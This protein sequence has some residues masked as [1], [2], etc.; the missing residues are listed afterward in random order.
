MEKTDVLVVGAGPAGSVV[1]KTIA[2]A[3]FSVQI[4]EEHPVVGLPLACGEGMS[5][6]M[7]NRFPWA[8]KEGYPLYIQYINFPGGYRTYS[9]IEAISLNRTVFDQSLCEMA[10][11]EG[12]QLNTNTSVKKLTRTR[13]GIE[14]TTN[15]GTTSAKVVIAADGPSSRMMRQMNLSPPDELIQ[16]IEY[17]IRDLEAE[18]LQFHFDYTIAPHGYGWIFDKGE[19]TANVGIC[20]QG[21][22]NPRARLDQFMRLHNINGGIEQ[23]IAGIIPSSGPVKQCYTD[24]FMVVGDAGGFTNPMFFGGI[25]IAMLTGMIAGET[26]V[27]ALEEDNY[28]ADKLIS[29]SQKVNELP[30][31][32]PN[33]IRAHNLF[34][35][36]CNNKDL[37][38]IGILTDNQDITHLTWGKKIIVFGRTLRRPRIWGG[39]SKISKIM[40]GFRLSRDWGF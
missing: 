30:I 7:L 5:L 11:N 35:H 15:H 2:E 36:Q 34:Y 4:H 14:A 28:S 25:G 23:V 27:E 9:S 33:L 24:H 20:L 17:R 40:E 3:G 13:G 37:A 10:Q 6:F 38:N 22:M 31:A 12:A 16:G 29:Y 1:A 21:A 19:G 18:G 32:A 39:I 8:P 26:A